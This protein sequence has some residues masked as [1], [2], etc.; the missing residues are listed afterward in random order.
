MDL[1]KENIQDL[2][3]KY[4]IEVLKEILEPSDYLEFCKH[5][6]LENTVKGTYE[7]DSEGNIAVKGSL[8]IQGLWDTIPVKFSSVTGVITV[9]GC[10]YLVSLKGLPEECKEVNIQSVPNIEDL[11]GCPVFK[12]KLELV[13]LNI[14]TL[15]GSGKFSSIHIHSCF[16]KSLKG[17]P[18]SCDDFYIFNCN[19]LKTLE[20]APLQCHKIQVSD[21]DIESLK[22]APEYT[23]EFIID[24]CRN[25]RT[26][27]SSCK[28][29]II[30]VVYKC[31]LIENLKGSPLKY[32]YLDLRDCFTFKSFEGISKNCHS[33]TYKKLGNENKITV[34]V[35]DLKTLQ[36]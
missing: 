2:Y 16:I 33:V 13:N 6:F 34:P 26:L 14:K 8:I 32:K 1:F 17:S 4:S 23:E 9:R 31:N 5:A 28:E 15:E 29:C 12:T 18:S 19:S 21:S 25:L 27:E 11:K 36:I 7:E 24:N 3:G 10:P 35:S 22:G 20:G 30:L